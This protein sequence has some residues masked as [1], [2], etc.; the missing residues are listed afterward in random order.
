MNIIAKLL[1]LSLLFFFFSLPVLANSP[2]PNW[3]R[4]ICDVLE[5]GDNCVDKENQQ[6]TC[7]KKPNCEEEIETILDDGPYDNCLTCDCPNCEYLTYSFMGCQSIS[8]TTGFGFFILAG[9]LFL[10]RWKSKLS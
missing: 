3:W 2:D 9:F 6:G 4:H 8:I 5:E 7:I 1:S 10:S